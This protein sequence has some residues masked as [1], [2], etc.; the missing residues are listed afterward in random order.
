MNPQTDFSPS[1]SPRILIVDE[2]QKF[3]QEIINMLSAAGFTCQGCTTIEAATVAVEAQRPHLIL[4]ALD[5]QGVPGMEIFRYARKNC[6]RTD[7][8]VM[9]LSATQ[10]PDVI[11]RRDDGHGIYY[12]RRRLK[13]HVLLDLIEKVLPAPAV[14]GA[15]SE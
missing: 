1:I 13:G 3:L 9:F 14:L 8:P 2:D 11:R 12:L 5:V 7:L 10:M 6:D 15:A 4:T